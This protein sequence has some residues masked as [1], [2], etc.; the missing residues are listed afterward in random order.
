MKPP[1]FEVVELARADRVRVF[2][3]AALRMKAPRALF[4]FFACRHRITP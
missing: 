3:L 1:A 4:K 2:V